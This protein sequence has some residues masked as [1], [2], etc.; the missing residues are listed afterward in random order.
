MKYP[1]SSFVHQRSLL[2]GLPLQC[3]LVEGVRSLIWFYVFPSVFRFLVTDFRKKRLLCV[4]GIKNFTYLQRFT[5]TSIVFRD[6]FLLANVKHTSPSTEECTLS[7]RLC[8]FSVHVWVFN[9][10]PGREWWG[11][12]W[13]DKWASCLGRTLGC[14]SRPLYAQDRVPLQVP[15]RGQ[16]SLDSMYPGDPRPPYPPLFKFLPV[17]LFLQG[18]PSLNDRHHN[19]VCVTHDLSPIFR[20]LNTYFV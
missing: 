7:V 1:D 19:N 20:C 10:Y 4:E 15:L 17:S 13:L 2:K 11:G 3:S 18:R 16:P 9:L 12:R 5:G 14:R 6:V 8:V